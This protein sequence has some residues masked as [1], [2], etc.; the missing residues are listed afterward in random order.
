[1]CAFPH[2]L[3]LRA[4]HIPEVQNS[5][6][7]VLSCQG[8]PQGN[9]RLHPEIVEMISSQ[10]GRAEVDVFASE[11]STHCPLLYSLMEGTSPLGQDALAHAWPALLLYAFPPI[12]LIRVTLERVQ[13]NGHRL[14]LVV[15]NW[16]GRQWFPV[17]LKLLQGETWRF[18]RRLDLLSQLEGH[19]WPLN[20]DRLQ[21]WVWQLGARNHSWHSVT[22]QYM[23]WPFW[24]YM[25]E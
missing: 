3:S 15:P 13:Q 21:L 12:P 10:Y 6:A 17:L 14:L 16:P 8:P 25:P 7:E 22:S 18:P 23:Q 24:Q 9:W 19:I 11:T 4:I 1:M 2:F 5:V 20:P